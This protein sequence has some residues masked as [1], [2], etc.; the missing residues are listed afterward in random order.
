MTFL[1]KRQVGIIGSI[2]RYICISAMR[3]YQ[4]RSG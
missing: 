2:A 3:F 4:I 1:V